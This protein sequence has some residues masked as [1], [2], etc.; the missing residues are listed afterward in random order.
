[1][2]I[3]GIE[4]SCDE[5]AASVLKIERGRFFILSSIVSS[6]I[7]IHRP[8]GGV[9]P[10]LAARNHIINILPV[11]NQAL[12][13]AKVKP[14]GID[15]IATT[16]GPGLITA[17]LIGVETARVLAQQWQKPIIATNHLKGHLYSSW[18]ENKPIRYPALCLIVS[19]GHT[20]LILMKSSQSLKKIGA[21]LDD[22]AGESFDKVAQMLGLGYPGGPAISKLA[23]T[24]NAAAFK[25]PR[26]MVN[27]P[28]FNFSFAGLKTAVLYTKNKLPKI[29]QQTKA[30][31]AASFQQA[32][33]DVLVQKTIKA[34]QHYKAKTVMLTGGVAANR[35]LRV[36]L[37]QAVGKIK[38]S[39]IVPP[40]KLCTDNAAIIAA[41]GYFAKPSPWQK[42]T[43]DPNLE[44]R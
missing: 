13:K 10:E 42:L 5:T 4:T 30:D 27:E 35:Q 6:Q 37:G 14:A 44:I 39:F 2:I 26:P 20:E 11:I 16:T 28:N 40:I 12:T 38:A 23:K 22:A 25:F 9:V 3:L 19:G 33:T 24:G 8:Y 7:D 34:A 31:L 29:D 36:E 21:T 41:A 15:R 18:L 32:A 17:L 1:M 43:A